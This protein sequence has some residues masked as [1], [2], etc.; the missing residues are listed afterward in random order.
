MQLAQHFAVLIYPF[1]HAMEGR[2]RRRR[3]EQ[4]GDRWRPWWQR[5]PAEG[6]ARAFGE[7][8]FFL[9]YVRA[10]LY[11]E[12]SAPQGLALADA[13]AATLAAAVNP[14]GVL[15]LSLAA[16]TLASF[17]RAELRFER[18]GG[19]PFAA[20]VCVEWADALFFPQ[21]VGFL[22]LRVA[23][24]DQ[25]LS[26]AQLRDLLALARQVLPPDH[27]W[28]MPCWRTAEGA[29]FSGEELVN[30]L[31]Q[32]LTPGPMGAPYATPM[33]LAAAPPS[34]AAYTDSDHA[35]VYGRAFRIYSYACLADA[36][37]GDA[38]DTPPFERR[39]RRTLYELATCADTSH[40]DF[41]PHAAAVEQLFARGH[42]AFWS[43]WEGLA[44][45]DNVAFLALRPGSFTQGALA[46]NV[47]A[48]YLSLYVLALYQK[49]RLSL[50]SGES[51][52]E[53]R[54]ADLYRNLRAARQL[55]DSL[56]KFRNLYWLREV[57]VRPQ[58]SELYQRFRSGLGT[59][60]VYEAVND[61]VHELQGYYEQRSQRSI[62]NALNLVA[63]I[64]LPLSIL[65]D[66]YGSN[67][68]PEQPWVSVLSVAGMV[69][70]I[71]GLV[72]WLSRL[73]TGKLG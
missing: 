33:A 66:L 29:C 25:G 70:G 58:G 55:W 57:T 63:F 64:G 18:P 62:S 22:A 47:G 54:R 15:R 69:F 49:L 32:G 31:L 12:T 73:L 44:L 24:A 53:S 37:G 19:E 20:P 41:V 36:D 51:M 4:L 39:A 65:L 6:R 13:P 17:A 26:A 30:F 34:A 48:E 52:R 14:R 42:L 28:A 11:P 9:P 56:V 1:V 61:A 59:D 50:M 43:N 45:H 60:A 21:G 23:A 40:A 46:R 7:T 10:L 2:E 3:L 68:F 27:N 8:Y 38:P 16:E 72:W 71:S 5:L 67:L 35:Q